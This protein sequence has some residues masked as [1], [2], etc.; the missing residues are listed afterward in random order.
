MIVQGE[1]LRFN[2]CDGV[3]EVSRVAVIPKMS[4][5][6]KFEANTTMSVLIDPSVAF[7][8]KNRRKKRYIVTIPNSGFHTEIVEG[9][10]FYYKKYRN[11]HTIWAKGPVLAELLILVSKF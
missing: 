7:V 9:T 2:V 5:E 3:V 4:R 6:I 1:G 8:L 10:K 11:K